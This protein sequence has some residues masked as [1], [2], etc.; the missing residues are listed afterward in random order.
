MTEWLRSI[1]LLKN[2]TTVSF[3]PTITF[4]GLNAKL[5]VSIGGRPVPGMSGGVRGEG[6]RKDAGRREAP[7]SRTTQYALTPREQKKGSSG[8]AG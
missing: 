4:G 5:D 2:Q 1:E 7:H 6:C 8:Q 3:W